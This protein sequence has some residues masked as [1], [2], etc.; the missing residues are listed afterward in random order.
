MARRREALAWRAL[1]AWVQLEVVEAQRG[2]CN[3]MTVALSL[4]FNATLDTCKHGLTT[5][6][7]CTMLGT[8]G[9]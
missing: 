9:S 3:G 5:G 7:D 2:I 1:R 8:E 4:G 6:I